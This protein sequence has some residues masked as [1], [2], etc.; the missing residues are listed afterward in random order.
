MSFGP[1]L[2]RV[3]ADDRPFVKQVYFDTQR[4]LIEKLF[5]WRGDEI[6]E[7]KFDESYDQRNTYIVQLAGEDVGWVTVLREPDR[8]EVDSIYLAA[9]QQGQGYGTVLMERI[10]AE[11]DAEGKPVTL[12]T[13][14]INPARRLYE[15]LGFTAVNQS[16]FKV[17]MRRE[18]S[19]Q[20]GFRPLTRADFNAMIRWHAQ[21]HAARWFAD[22]PLDLHTAEEKY[23]PRVDGKTPTRMH[24]V[25]ISNATVGYLQHYL[26]QDYP[27]YLSAVGYKD[28]AGIDFLIGEPNYVGK[29]FGPR[30]LMRYI[31]QIVVPQCPSIRRVV[32]TPDPENVRSIR[33]LEKAGFTQA[34]TIVVDGKRE[35][36]C[37][38]ELQC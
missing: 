13:A 20:I 22:S 25:N 2:R 27:D 3:T 17:Y 38:L 26:V 19:L 35:R 14:K 32:S 37:V 28:A 12:S 21:P 36:L 23:G 5:G 1:T 9:A 8:V 4:W 24:V 6:E 30:V 33:T 10:I 29:G 7:A 34:H 15:R 18:P 31:S 11:A 16:E